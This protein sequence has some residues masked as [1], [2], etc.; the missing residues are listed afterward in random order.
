MAKLVSS[1][2]VKTVLPFKPDPNLNNLSL[3]ILQDVQFSEEEAPS[4]KD[5][6]TP[7]PYQF[8]GMKVPRLTF[9][10]KQHHL[11]N[12]PDKAD[13]F[14]FHSFTP[15]VT[16]K[17]DG[18]AM[19]QKD[20]EGLYDNMFNHIIH[21]H[22]TFEG[23]PNYKPLVDMEIDENAPVQE[24]LA[25]TATTFKAIQES[26]M[27]GKDGEKPIFVDTKGNYIILYVKLVTSKD[28]TRLEFPKFVQTGFLEIFKAGV[29]PSIELLVSRGET[30]TLT[31][32][33]SKKASAAP[34]TEMPGA[35]AATSGIPDMGALSP[36]LKAKLGMV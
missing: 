11:S 4:L 2:Q 23:T 18:T 8:A 14:Y 6:G 29:L 17:N 1:K 3:G 12:S 10:F 28:G 36:E 21:M 22:T 19:E 33:N 35:P 13:R 9:V 30:I 32:K 7:N 26:F 34:N 15:I 16:V 5:D 20:V 27:K 25:Q 31:A 24:L